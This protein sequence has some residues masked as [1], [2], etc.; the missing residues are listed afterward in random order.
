MNTPFGKPRSHR[1]AC[2]NALDKLNTE[3]GWGWNV[4]MSFDLN[5]SN[6]DKRIAI[7]EHRDLRLLLDPTSF[8]DRQII[9]HD[10]WEPTQLQYLFQLIS[11]HGQDNNRTF[12]D[13]GAYF[14]LYSLLAAQSGFF[15]EIFSFEADRYTYGQLQGNI[16]LNK[17]ERL[18]LATHAAVS[19]NSYEGI[20]WEG[21]YHPDNNRA[22]V[23]LAS[24]ETSET[25]RVQC[26]ALDRVFHF[27][28]R[29]IVIKID[30][31]GHE[32]QAL[33]GMKRILSENSITLQVEAYEPRQQSLF[34]FAASLGLRHLRTIDVDHYFA[35]WK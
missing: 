9:V 13:V 19:D 15:S 18:I 16:F 31:E 20:F 32:L 25:T 12:I 4:A 33:T 21:R 34:E 7:F 5:D 14:G 11:E 27:A 23:G 3:W 29:D 24:H 1:N 6:E 28:G 17:F 22:G 26:L 10:A 8:V 35:N 2:S 30:V